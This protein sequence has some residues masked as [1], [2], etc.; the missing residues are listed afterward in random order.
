VEEL[1]VPEVAKRAL[2]T[3]PRLKLDAFKDVIAEPSAVITFA[4]KFPEASR[5]TIVEAP[6]DEEAVVRA[7]LIV[8]VLITDAL[9]PVTGMLIFAEPLKDVAVPVTP[10]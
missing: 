1:A 2:G 7:L 6:F 4:L 8:P 5:A 3:D 9:I 10:S